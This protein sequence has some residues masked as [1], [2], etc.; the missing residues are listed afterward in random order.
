MTFAKPTRPLILT[1]P[2]LAMWFWLIVPLALQSLAPLSGMTGRHFAVHLGGWIEDIGYADSIAD[3][4]NIMRETRRYSQCRYVR[5][6]DGMTSLVLL[7]ARNQQ[8][9][10]LHFPDKRAGRL[11]RSISNAELMKNLMRSIN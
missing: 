1:G 9:S 8:C 3:G 4:L 11:V 6:G 5:F 2:Y 10:L 7:P